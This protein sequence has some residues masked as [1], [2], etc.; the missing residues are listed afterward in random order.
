M[1]PL[2]FKD[3]QIQIYLM[4]SVRITQILDIIK[5]EGYFMICKDILKDL[6]NI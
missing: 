3:T 4:I 5:T 1:T 2:V 6:G